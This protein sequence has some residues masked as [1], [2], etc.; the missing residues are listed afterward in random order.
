MVWRLCHGG[1]HLLPSPN[2]FMENNNFEN[3]TPYLNSTNT[4]TTPDHPKDMSTPTTSKALNFARYVALRTAITGGE[5][6]TSGEIS[7]LLK[8]WSNV[9]ELNASDKN[10][11]PLQRQDGVEEDQSTESISDIISVSSENLDT[12]DQKAKRGYKRAV[13][14]CRKF[15]DKDRSAITEREKCL[16]KTNLKVVRKYEKNHPHLPK[17]SP[18]FETLLL[19]ATGF[20]KRT[21]PTE[22][23]DMEEKKPFADVFWNTSAVGALDLT[24]TPAVRSSPD[25]IE[26]V[27]PSV[28][29]SRTRKRKKNGPGTIS[30]SNSIASTKTEISTPNTTLKRR[31]STEEPHP[32][33]KTPTL[34]RISMTQV[35]SFS[36]P[37]TSQKTVTTK[38]DNA[39]TIQKSNLSQTATSKSQQQGQQARKGKYSHT[40]YPNHLRLAIIDKAHPEG[41]ISDSR[42][43]LI[44]ECL[45]DIVFSG[46]GSPMQ[47]QFGSATLYKGVKVICCENVE[48]KDFLVKTVG[49][50]GV[51]WEGSELAAVS[52]KEIPCGRKLSAW[53]PPPL[54]DPARILTILAKQNPNLQT[55]NWH[56]VNSSPDSGGLVIKVAID[57]KGQEYLQARG[58]KLHFGSGWIRFRITPTR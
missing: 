15:I 32:H 53:V 39:Q 5:E 14:Y 27:A 50:L 43:L 19:P 34:N 8:V 38:V 23:S 46:A 24:T 2:A 1:P 28:K 49:E 51:L 54:V 36:F 3:I 58:G 30:T 41:R 10:H 13:K 48:S 33:V 26:H 56:I 22:G 31:R 29:K 12:K 18:D 9:E 45:R 16:I 7:A 21:C 57:A 42:W 20:D 52:L 35:S 25:P 37:A 6:L 11:E 44:E 17:I 55:D 47:M 4:L 40:M